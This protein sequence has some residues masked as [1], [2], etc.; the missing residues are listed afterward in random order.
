MKRIEKHPILPD[1]PAAQIVT[2]DFEGRNLT[3]IEGEPIAAALAAAGIAD[4]RISHRFREARGIFCGIGQCQ[5][6]VMV[7]N[8]KANV[9]SCITPL[10]EG[11]II[12]RQE[13]RGRMV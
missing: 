1:L 3:G 10:E 4:L 12:R 6:C 11:M 7:V 2:F 5:E 8:G 9:R 13:G